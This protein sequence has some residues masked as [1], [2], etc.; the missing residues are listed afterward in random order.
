M[1]KNFSTMHTLV[2]VHHFQQL[3]KYLLAVNQSCTATEIIMSHG[4]KQDAICVLT[5]SNSSETLQCTRN[6][7][8]IKLFTL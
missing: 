2:M 7:N 4:H 6:A 8:A 3:Y 1:A 5:A